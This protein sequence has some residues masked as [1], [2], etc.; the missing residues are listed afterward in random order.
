MWTA[1]RT[2]EDRATLLR[3]MAERA[4]STGNVRTARQFEVTA[5]E[6]VDQAATIRL[7]IVSLDDAALPTSDT[8]PHAHEEA[9]G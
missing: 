4:R 8:D 2:L 7:A 3:R 9:T 5:R 6:A 1:A